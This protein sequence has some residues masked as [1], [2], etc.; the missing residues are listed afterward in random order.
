[1]TGYLGKQTNLDREVTGSQ[2]QSDRDA[3]SGPIPGVTVSAWNGRTVNVQPLYKPMHNGQPVSMPVLFDVPLDQP[4]TSGGGMTFPVPVGTPVMLTPQMR[5]MDDWEDGGEATAYDARSFHLST[6]RA[7]LTGGESL[8]QEIADIDLENFHLRAN[9]SGSF[10]LKASPDGKFKLTGAEGDIIDLL[11]EVCET[12]GVLTTTVSGGSSS[13]IW[14][15]TQQAQ[16]AALAAR[17]RA[18]VL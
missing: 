4:M 2:I 10:G 3:M 15:I 7:S 18:M 8:S 6:M 14:P 16:L 11:A 13:G 9:A 5:A 1:M 12:L 17:L